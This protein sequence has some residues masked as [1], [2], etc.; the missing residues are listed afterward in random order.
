MNIEVI[1]MLKGKLDEGAFTLEQIKMICP[2]YEKETEVL[3]LLDN[4][5]VQDYLKLMAEVGQKVQVHAG[6]VSF[7]L[8]PQAHPAPTAAA[9]AAAPMVRRLAC[10]LKVNLELVQGTGPGGRITEA[11]VRRMASASVLLQ[12]PLCPTSP[13]ISSGWTSRRTSRMAPALAG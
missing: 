9:I 2:D 1:K 3:E 4:P 10:E 12:E 11:D 6:L 13:T 8:N 5:F 7:E